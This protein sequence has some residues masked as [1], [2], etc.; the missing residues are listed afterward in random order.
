MSPPSPTSPFDFD[1]SRPWPRGTERTAA[2]GEAGLLLGAGTLLAPFAAGVAK[3]AGRL[4]VDPARVLALLAVAAGR[5]VAAARVLDGI[6]AADHWA[7]GDRARANIRLLFAGLPRLAG[8]VD[9]ERLR[10]AASLLDGGM[11]PRRLMEELDLDTASLE[12][13]AADH[14]AKYNPEQPA[15]RPATALRAAGGS[16][17]TAPSA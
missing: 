2:I 16:V 4:A 11:T 5:P 8:P 3:E 6:A 7:R 10:A 15:C 17:R 13:A 12:E 14:L 1:P 9:A